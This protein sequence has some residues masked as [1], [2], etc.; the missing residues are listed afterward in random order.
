M[1]LKSLWRNVNPNDYV[2]CCVIGCHGNSLL[3]FGLNTNVSCEGLLGH[4]NMNHDCMA[5]VYCNKI[6][7]VA[8]NLFLHT[9]V[10]REHYCIFN[11]MY[12]FLIK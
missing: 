1:N 3:H 7:G 6:Q 8:L 11:K 5:Y 2:H 4:R 9:H 12:S 10:F